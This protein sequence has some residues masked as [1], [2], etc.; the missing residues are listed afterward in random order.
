MKDKSR[1]R[2]SGALRMGRARRQ[3]AAGSRAC[4]GKF[5]G[6]LEDGTPGQPD[7]RHWRG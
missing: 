5:R 7:P 4:P 6:K 1:S 2:Q 3:I